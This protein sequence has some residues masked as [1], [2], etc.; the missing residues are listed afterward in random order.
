MPG[1]YAAHV[2]GFHQNEQV[3]LL[4]WKPVNFDRW[5]CL[6]GATSETAPVHASNLATAI[7]RMR[8]S[9]DRLRQ[10]L[11]GLF[12][13]SG[14]PGT[15][16]YHHFHAPAD[17]RTRERALNACAADYETFLV[18]LEIALQL[19]VRCISGPASLSMQNWKTLAEA[20]ARADPGLGADAR[21]EILYL[22]RTVLYARHKG[23][24]HPRDH[25]PFVSFDNLGNVTFWRIASEPSGALLAELNALVH[26]VRPEI[27]PNAVVGADIP[28]H[29]ALTLVGSAAS[30]VASPDRLDVLRAGLGYTFPGPNEVAP[31]VD[32]MVDAFVA[33]LPQTEFGKIAFAAGPTAKRASASEPV[34]VTG[35][36]EPDNPELLK[37]VRDDAIHAGLEGRHQEALRPQRHTYA[38]QICRTASVSCC[39]VSRRLTC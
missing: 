25:I 29:L 1:L 20:A 33:A 23:V 3:T 31:A 6:A 8:L 9:W 4:S 5:L 13:P 18:H 11:I 32:A 7:E 22:Q 27:G 2:R 34:E 28:V 19:S 24:V 14:P 12:V 30:H 17:P 16:A 10:D 39:R 26:Q 15:H 36:V 21:D 38:G 35:P 37:Q